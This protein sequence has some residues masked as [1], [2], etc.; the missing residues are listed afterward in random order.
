[1]DR[2]ALSGFSKRGKIKSSLLNVRESLR[3]CLGSF[4]G[5]LL[6]LKYLGKKDVFEQ[7]RVKPL[8]TKSFLNEFKQGPI[9]YRNCSFIPPDLKTVTVISQGHE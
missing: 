3:N 9:L 7:L 1:M 5:T 2:G 8:A 6:H 4:E